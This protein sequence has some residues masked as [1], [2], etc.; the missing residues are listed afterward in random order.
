MCVCRRRLGC[1]LRCAICPTFL[2]AQAWRTHLLVVDY[3]S[4]PFG[5]PKR[6]MRLESGA[7]LRSDN[8][9]LL[10]RIAILAQGVS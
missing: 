5:A 8:V 4:M 3:L 7:I 9:G 6:P 2:E 10:L 1:C